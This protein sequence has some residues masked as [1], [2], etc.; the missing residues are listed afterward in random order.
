MSETLQKSD[1]G[2]DSP[3]AQLRRENAVLRE[4]QVLLEALLDAIGDPILYKD[5]EGVYLGCNAAYRQLVGKSS[6]ELFP[7]QADT[8]REGD[9]QVLRTLQPFRHEHEAGWPD[10]R[11]TMME[12]VRSPLCDR[13]GRLLGIVAIGRDVTAR[14][15]QQEEVQRSK[16]LAEDANR[17][18]SDFLANMSH[19]I[20]TPMNAVIGLSHLV[21]KTD[22]AP[23][24][25]DYIQKVQAAGQHLL[26]IIDDILDFS[27]IEAGKLDLEETGFTPRQLLDTAG[28]LLGERCRDKRLGLV[29]DT[30][31]DV[32]H[33]L[34]GDP[35]R[36]G[37]ILLNYLNNA[38]KFTER[39]RIAVSVSVREK[40]A[41]NVLLEVQVQDTG[42]G[43][44]PEQQSRLF[45]S[46]SQADTSTTRRFGGTGLG[47]AICRRL[48]GLMGGEVGVHSVA[49]Y[50]STFWFTARLRIDHTGMPG[51]IGAAPAAAVTWHGKRVLLVEDNDINQEVARELL[52]DAGI[53]VDVAEHGEAALAM[54]VAADYDLVFM[55]MQMPVMDGVTATREIRRLP[56][57][58]HLPI[59]AM[60]A[61][62]MERERRLCIEAGM[63]G[64][65]A[66]PID[67]GALAAVLQRWLPNRR[68]G[69]KAA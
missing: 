41:D 11:V 30:A 17:M 59:V 32:P 15:Q 65:L 55:D 12:S 2:T 6:A 5:P 43:L 68:A 21:L 49:G 4:R 33:A 52:R 23:R 36:L 66:K 31:P 18:K 16:E 44:T 20:R 61:N 29:F 37:Q 25:R 13:A 54:L 7:I 53:A 26:G 40:T 3:F 38:V 48:A 67:L 19:E 42:I 56:R 1:A 57:F 9:A 39:G 69:G 8:V 14:K 63:D 64:Y 34:L 46:F 50:G 28:A 24:Q 60:T 58:D 22:L 27:K 47:L 62:A 51:A 10:G 45:Q 35:L